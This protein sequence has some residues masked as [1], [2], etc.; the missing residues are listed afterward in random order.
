MFTIHEYVRYTRETDPNISTLIDLFNFN[1]EP[2]NCLFT[3]IPLRRCPYRPYGVR[4]QWGEKRHGPVKVGDPSSTPVDQSICHEG[5]KA[6]R[7]IS[8]ITRKRTTVVHT[9][10]CAIRDLLNGN[11]SSP[12]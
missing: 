12:A 6:F 4:I 8:I 3:I 11:C 1:F 10:Y 7:P 9:G 2:F 5:E